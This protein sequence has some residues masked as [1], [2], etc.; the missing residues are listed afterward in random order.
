MKANERLTLELAESK[1]NLS[2]HNHQQM[3]TLKHK[4]EVHIGKLTKKLNLAKMNS[5]NLQKNLDELKQN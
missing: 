3:E 2:N 4:Y 1:D 5:Q